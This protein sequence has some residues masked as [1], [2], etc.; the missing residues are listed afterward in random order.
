[1]LLIFHYHLLSIDNPAG[2]VPRLSAAQTHRTFPTACKGS[3]VLIPLPQ[4]FVTQPLRSIRVTPQVSEL[5]YKHVNLEIQGVLIVVQWVKN[6]TSIHED[7]GLILCL[8]QWVKDPAL[9]M[10]L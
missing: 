6:L 1:M 10:W 3:T 7:V 8:A 5:G 4:M 2:T 9:Q